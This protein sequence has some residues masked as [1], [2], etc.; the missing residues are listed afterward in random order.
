M[1]RLNSS[2]LQSLWETNKNAVKSITTATGESLLADT[3]EL[4]DVNHATFRRS[5]LV[6]V[7]NYLIS[8]IKSIL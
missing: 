3:F 1:C 7:Q 6:V 2:E 8:N 5:G 4:T